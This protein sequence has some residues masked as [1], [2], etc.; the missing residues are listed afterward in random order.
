VQT[1]GLQLVGVYY[2]NAGG[3][4]QADTIKN[5]LLPEGYQGCQSGLGIYVQNA[6]AGTDPVVITA[7]RSPISTRTVSP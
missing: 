3:T 2:R 1:C 4:I 6:N 7:T 5:Q